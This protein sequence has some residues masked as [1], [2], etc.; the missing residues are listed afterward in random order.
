MTIALVK[1][2]T[3]K[4]WRS[5]ETYHRIE[6]SLK[7]RWH[8]ESIATESQVKLQRFFVELQD[9]SREDVFVFNI[10]EYLDEK[11]KTG[12]LPALLD[13][14]GVPHLGSS[15]EV[16]AVSLDK[17]ATKR[18]LDE[19]HV[20]TPQFFVAEQ[21]TFEKTLHAHTLRFPLIVKPVME[22]GHI[23]IDKD[24]IVYDENTLRT[25]V[26]RIFEHYHQPALVEEF[27]GGEGM[28]EFSVGIIDSD[29][30]LFLPVEIDFEAMELGDGPAILSFD[31]AQ[32]DL[33][34]IKP[35]EDEKIRNVLIELTEKTFDAIG[36]RDYA[37]VDLRMD[38][39][40]CYVLEI[41][42]MPGLG[43]ESFLPKAARRFYGLDYSQL[44]Q[45][46]AEVS[47]KRQAIKEKN[48]LQ[49]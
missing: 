22:G 3:N 35:V 28:R 40:G 43:P 10:A 38:H 24:S 32:K 8:V 11:R 25:A 12:F 37:R 6:E 34:R 44:M 27:I 48:P 19:H 33:E 13:A 9:A 16:V 39:T 26:L 36:A 45:M 4:P 17:G 30:R 15:A 31:A 18:L 47:M 2:F 14:W 49:N 41:N 7:K 1:S 23:G 5:P 21:N 46:L 20:S 29:E 42:A